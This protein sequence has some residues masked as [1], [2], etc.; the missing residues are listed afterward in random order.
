VLLLLFSP[1]F[2]A[3]YATVLDVAPDD[4]VLCSA[5]V[6]QGVVT[7]AP[8]MLAVGFSIQ[9]LKLF[10][11]THLHCP[12]LSQ[13]SYIKT[14]SDLHSV[15]YQKYLSRQFS[16]AF[17]VYLSICAAV[18]DRVK[19][20]LGQSTAN[21]QLQHAC[22]PCMYRLKEKPALLFSFLLAMDGN[23]SLRCV[24]RQGPANDE[25]PNKPRTSCRRRLRTPCLASVNWIVVRTGPDNF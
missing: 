6:Q 20:A 1:K 15:Q 5:F 16:I 3:S 12:Q 23:D 7:C 25:D 18:D 10:C 4:N 8:I 13:Q 24:M 2:T 17:D 11:I 14:L 9:A 19:K 21:W 22:P